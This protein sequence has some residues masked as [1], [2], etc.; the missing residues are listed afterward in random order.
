M[1][2][3]IINLEIVENKHNKVP[4][5]VSMIPVFKRSLFATRSS[6]WAN[7]SKQFSV[8]TRNMSIEYNVI[9]YDKPNVDRTKV[10]P[11][12][13]AA[14]ASVVN[15]GIVKAAGAIYHDDAK[16]KFA[17]SAFHLVADSKEDVIEFL[18]RD[19]YYKEGIWDIENVIINPIGLAVR[20]PK[21]FD[22]VSEVLYQV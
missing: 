15:S 17:G 7:L 2:N 11:A 1:T 14:I 16:T 10:R 21:K 18:K 4:M 9:V 6:T 13:V 22:G 3:C 8:S 19:I 20:L 5:K 12:H